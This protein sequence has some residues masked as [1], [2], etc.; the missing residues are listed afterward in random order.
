[1]IFNG[2]QYKFP[3]GYSEGTIE[4]FFVN[5]KVMQSC[6]QIYK[7]TASSG[8]PNLSL[9]LFGLSNG[10]SVDGRKFSGKIFTFTIYEGD[11]RKRHF[12]PAKRNSDNAVGMY[13]LVEHTF[14][15]NLGTGSFT[16][17]PELGPLTVIRANNLYEI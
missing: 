17:G 10:G 11:E 3:I 2:S 14:Y 6:S 12:I 13:D 8:S 5:K 4:T 15:P 1:M 9:I 7:Y 16:A